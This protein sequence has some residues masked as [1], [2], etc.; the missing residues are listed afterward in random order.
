MITVRDHFVGWDQK[1]LELVACIHPFPAFCSSGMFH[2]SSE[3]SK[4]LIELINIEL[5]G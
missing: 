1:T 3:A 4:S 5:W 2:A